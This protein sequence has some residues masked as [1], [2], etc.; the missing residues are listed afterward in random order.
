[1]KRSCPV[2]PTRTSSRRSA[3]SCCSAGLRPSPRPSSPKTASAPSR[4]RT[5]P[6][7]T[8]K[9]KNGAI[10]TKKIKN[11]TVTTAK[12][13][14]ATVATSDLA[15]N[16]VTTGKIADNAVTTGKITNAAVTTAKLANNSVTSAKI[17]NG[18]IRAGDLGKILDSPEHCPDRRGYRRNGRRRVPSR[19]G[20]AQRWRLL[21]H[22]R[23]QSQDDP[24][25]RQRLARRG[26]TRPR[27]RRAAD[28]A[29]VLPDWMIR[30]L[31]PREEG[32]LP[33]AATVAL[34]QARPDRSRVRSPMADE[35]LT[36]EESRARAAS[37][38][39]LDLI[40]RLDR[41]G[42]LEGAVQA[43]IARSLEVFRLRAAVDP[44]AGLGP[45]PARALRGVAQAT[46][47]RTLA[48]DPRTDPHRRPPR[49]HIV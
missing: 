8:A 44:R 43:G 9:I 24:Q 1:M 15:D 21:D 14:D 3:C 30:S 42:L 47:P 45:R 11:G 34:L 33:R 49:V 19:L 25:A 40:D 22:R 35:D 46:P 38:E 20:A 10:T 48:A 4:S 17:V 18:Q 16:A 6:S 2:P 7:P 36:L 39:L 32:G 31:A 26:Q 5:T 23:E 37:V 27:R 28:G 12:I 41:W 29:G 13:A